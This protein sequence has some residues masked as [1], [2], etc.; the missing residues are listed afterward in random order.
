MSV[1]FIIQ[2]AQCQL[3]KKRKKKEAQYQITKIKNAF[4]KLFSD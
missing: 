1:V 2:Q 4:N 3:R